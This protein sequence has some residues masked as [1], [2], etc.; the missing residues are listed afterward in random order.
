MQ[1]YTLAELK[2]L[3]KEQDYKTA[4]LED[5]QGT[6]LLGFNTLKTCDINEQLNKIEKRIKS[7][8]I[9]NGY[10]NVCMA[11]NPSHQRNPDKFIIVKG[12]LSEAAPLPSQAP[13]QIIIEKEKSAEVLTWGEAL[14]LH[15]ELAA[16]REENKAL[17][18]KIEIYEDEESE[19]LSEA[20]PGNNINLLSFLKEQSP[21]F[22][23]LADRYFNLEE[24]KI[25]LQKSKLDL[26]SLQKTKAQP[27]QITPG[28]R[29]HLILIET[30]FN[31]GNEEALNKELA[32]LEACDKDLFNKVTERLNQQSEA[33]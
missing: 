18:D 22:I 19:N 21:V 12:N 7:V 8:T 15:A 32:K 1:T 24:K 27:K 28:S 2:K 30:Y 11:I 9:P 17:R 33:E 13:Q 25:D 20:A 6:R 16:L 10:L 5:L 23:S 31:N 29:E 3:I 26:Q 4:A 14:K